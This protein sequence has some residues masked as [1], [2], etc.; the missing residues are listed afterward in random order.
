M[1]LLSLA[2]LH[3]AQEILSAVA[4]HTPLLPSAALSELAG[5]QVL[6]KCENL[7]RTGSFKMRGA[8]VRMARLDAAEK[9]RGVVAASAGNHAQGV[10]LAAQR[11]GIS[12]TVYMPENAALPKVV[13]TQRYGARIRQVGTTVAESLAAAEEDA[14]STGRVL[15]HPFE[16]RD[17]IAGQGTIGLEILAAAPDVGTVLVPTGGGGLLAGIASAL[18][19]GG[20]AARIIGVQAAGAAAFGRSMELGHPITLDRVATMA[21]GIAV[22]EPG[23]LTLDIARSEVHG[24]R[25]VG[26]ESIAR[27]I[28]LLSERTK[29][30]VEPAGAVGVAALLE[31]IEVGEGPVVVVLSGGNIDT[32]V[33][34]RVLRHGLT[35]AGR[36][37]Q[38]WVRIPDRPGSLANMLNLLAKAG[39]NVVNI[40]HTRTGSDL[41]FEE[42]EVGIELESRGVEHS[43]EVLDM[44]RDHGF[45]VETTTNLRA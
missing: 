24:I 41:G 3:S 29:V 39:S 14:A 12:A 11:L 32:L 2:E 30:V 27:A 45:V 44:L 34:N 15:V 10:A 16:H 20:S 37:M 7:Q 9:A 38:M 1:N 35:T 8:Y 21:D 17:I 36:Y 33:L 40:D 42:V 19:G 18:R 5:R 22:P 31:D 13:A 23:K 6:L 4:L 25:N 28:L 43:Q 26:E